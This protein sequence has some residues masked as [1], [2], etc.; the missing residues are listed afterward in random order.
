MEISCNLKSPPGPIISYRRNQKSN[1]ATWNPWI[2]TFA[3]KTRSL[4]TECHLPP[5]T[6]NHADAPANKNMFI[7]DDDTALFAVLLQGRRHAAAPYDWCDLKWP[8]Y[9]LPM[10]SS[11]GPWF[12]SRA[13]RVWP[14]EDANRHYVCAQKRKREVTLNGCLFP[15][16][17]A[18]N[19][20][21]VRS[22]GLKQQQFFLTAHELSCC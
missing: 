9:G 12:V 4:L 21:C 11:N 6:Q 16:L 18:F 19:L 7:F 1:T 20:N 13:K 22:M 5:K 15:V 2:I 10:Q 3:S 17:A 14:W 8:L